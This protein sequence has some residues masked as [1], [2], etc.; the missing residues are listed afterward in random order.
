MTTNTF[1][2]QNS[3]NTRTHHSIPAEYNAIAATTLHRTDRPAEL[4]YPHQQ[5]IHPTESELDEVEALHENG[6]GNEVRT[7]IHVALACLSVRSTLY[8]ML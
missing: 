8:K 5:T 2:S 7:E 6:D 1:A 3:R 4:T